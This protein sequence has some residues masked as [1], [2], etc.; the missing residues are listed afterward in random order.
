MTAKQWLSRAKKLETE[1]NNLL[2]L[3]ETTM[4][5]MLKITQTYDGDGAQATKDPHKFDRLVEINNQIDAK[6]DLLVD[7]RKEIFDIIYKIE[8]SRFRQILL[9]RYIAGWT[10]EQIAVSIH[11]S[12]KQTIRLHGFALMEIQRLLN[13]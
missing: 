5:K 9:E 7:T 1:I 12:Y 10:W 11:Y 2:A 13:G 6:I 8:D 3:K 4:D